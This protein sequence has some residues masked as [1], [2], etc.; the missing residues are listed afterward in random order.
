MDVVLVMKSLTCT[1]KL[2]FVKEV[3]D[4]YEFAAETASPDFYLVALRSTELLYH[5][6]RRKAHKHKLSLQ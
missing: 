3:A 1:R 6:N 5:H 2:C 4:L